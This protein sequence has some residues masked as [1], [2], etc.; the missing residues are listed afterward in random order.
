MKRAAIVLFLVFLSLFPVIWI[1]REGQKYSS[2][3]P[4]SG[5]VRVRKIESTLNSF[6]AE[7]TTTKTPTPTLV[8]F[9]AKKRIPLSHGPRAQKETV[10]VNP[11]KECIQKATIRDFTKDPVI[12]FGNGYPSGNEFHSLRCD[13]RCLYTSDL[14]RYRYTADATLVGGLS[15]PN[16]WEIAFSME[17]IELE[18][19]PGVYVMS[20]SKLSDVPVPY[21]SWSD[22]DIMRSVRNKSAKALASAFV[23][24]CVPER[25]SI[26]ETLMKEGVAIHSFGNCLHNKEE[27]SMTTE[28]GKYSRK[29]DIMSKYKVL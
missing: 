6:S 21:Y 20:V 15:C 2:I 29:I 12:V 1:L 9:I 7:T 16:Q 25:R 17:N 27:D 8:S 22:F 11:A 3:S 24:N 19:R 18:K 4:A 5:K 10:E 13:V 28:I 14:T 23:S 26:I